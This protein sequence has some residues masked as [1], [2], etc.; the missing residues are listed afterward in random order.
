VLQRGGDPRLAREALA[1][2]DR[3][4]EVRRDDL[5]GGSALGLMC[6]ARYTTPMPPRPIRSSIR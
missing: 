3:L 5:D 6:S 1:E 4:R 2:A